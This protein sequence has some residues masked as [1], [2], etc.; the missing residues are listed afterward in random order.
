MTKTWNEADNWKQLHII[1]GICQVCSCQLNWFDTEYNDICNYCYEIRTGQF[2][3]SKEE[4]IKCK[5][6]GFKTFF[7]RGDK[8]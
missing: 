4:E 7:E 5:N 2:P 1:T 6:C 8:A 3:E